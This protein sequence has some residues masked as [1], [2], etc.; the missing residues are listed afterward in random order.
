MRTRL[1]RFLAQ[2]DLTGDGLPR[3]LAALLLTAGGVFFFRVRALPV[4]AACVAGGGLVL[5]LLWAAFHRL[6]LRPLGP[7]WPGVHRGLAVTL[8]A[9]CLMPPG[10]PAYLA[11]LLAALAVGVEAVEHKA[12]VP[13]AFSGVTAAWLLAGLWQARAGSPYI[14]PFDFHVLDEPV[15]LWVRFD[16]VIDPVRAYAGQ[17]AGPLGATSFGLAALGTLLLSYA[18]KLSW[19]TVLA[20]YVP[21]SAICVVARLPLNVYLFNAPALVFAAVIAAD[22]RR[23]PRTIPWRVVTG[24]LGGAVA[25]TLLLAG[26]GYMA[27][28][29]GVALSTAL[30][31]LF[32][33]FGLAGAPGVLERP[34]ADGA[35]APD[36]TER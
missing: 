27:F 11:A 3:L 30:V 33:L 35:P 20:F 32:Q 22:A 5:A 16:T 6:G 23:L 26:S 15:A 13:L 7:Y 12:L 19:H 24:F 9:F 14:A 18:R 1:Q 2:P 10:I 28:G 17:V 31:T 21:I 25:A 8:L 36:Q 29:F 4:L 34:A